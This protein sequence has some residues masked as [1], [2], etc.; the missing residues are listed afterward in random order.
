MQTNDAR[1][2]SEMINDSLMNSL[3]IFGDLGG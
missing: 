2:V 1:F 3:V